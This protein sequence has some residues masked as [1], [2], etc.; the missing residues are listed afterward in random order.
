MNEYQYTFYTYFYPNDDFSYFILT[1]PENPLIQIKLRYD[2]FLSIAWI[3][4][5]IAFSGREVDARAWYSKHGPNSHGGLTFYLAWIHVYIGSL[6]LRKKV[7][8]NRLLTFSIYNI[9]MSKIIISL[10]LKKFVL[11]WYNVYVQNLIRMKFHSLRIY[12]LM[13]NFFFSFGFI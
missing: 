10:N 13:I 6:S 12:F 1:L 11:S 3:H 8:S 9:N 7:R 5:I 2:G 4:E